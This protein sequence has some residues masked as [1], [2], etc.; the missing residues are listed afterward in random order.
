[1]LYTCGTTNSSGTYGTWARQFCLGKPIRSKLLLFCWVLASTIPQLT[2]ALPQAYQANCKRCSCKALGGG[3]WGAKGIAGHH[4]AQRLLSMYCHQNGPTDVGE[5]ATNN[6]TNKIV[7]CH[8]TT[9]W[10][11][12]ARSVIDILNKPLFHK[13]VWDEMVFHD[14]CNWCR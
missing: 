12:V 11:G 9:I 7:G 13:A 4:I 1:V 5:F 10:H 14:T 2:S 3:L 8:A 6:S